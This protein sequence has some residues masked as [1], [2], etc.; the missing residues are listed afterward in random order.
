MLTHVVLF[1]FNPTAP[2]EHRQAVVADCTA[3]LSK[4]PTVKHITAGVAAGTPRDVVDNSYDVGLSVVFDDVA[5]L[6]VY[7]VHPLHKEFLAR[8]KQHFARVLVYDFH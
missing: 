6:D 7:Q 1:W 3:L 4:I 8:H 2:S 5:G